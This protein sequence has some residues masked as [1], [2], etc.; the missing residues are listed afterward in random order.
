ML[1][2]VVIPTW[3]RACSLRRTLTSLA[4]VEIGSNQVEVLV[5][6]NGSIDQTRVVFESVR[7]LPSP[8]HWEYIYEPMPG[9]LSG[10]HCGALR[11]RGDICVFIDD[12]VRLDKGWLTAIEN[13]FLDPEVSLVGGPSRPVYE[14]QPPAWLESFFCE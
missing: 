5:V 2:S 7:S 3:N 9:L 6:D 11:A 8:F 4:Q 1:F 13:S 10:R 12:D 14:S